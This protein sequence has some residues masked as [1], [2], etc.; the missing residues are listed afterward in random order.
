[1]NGV[2]IKISKGDSR[3]GLEVKSLTEEV[4][5]IL[6]TT[7]KRRNEYFRNTILLHLH[8]INFVDEQKS[9]FIT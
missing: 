9:C 7:E 3:A 5:E 1:M 8:L 6:V 2:F 4:H